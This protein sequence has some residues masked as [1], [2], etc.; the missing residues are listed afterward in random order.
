MNWNEV[1]V[2]CSSLYCLFTPPKSKEDKLAGNLSETAKT[3]L[4]K[5]YVEYMWGKRRQV[6]T[7][8]MEKG[9]ICEPEGIAMI[10]ALDGIAYVKNEERKSDEYITG[11]ADVV[12][13]KEVQDVKSCWDAESFIP[14]LVDGI[15]SADFYQMQGYMRL[16]NKPQARVPS[17]CDF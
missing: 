5:L 9:T 10:S 13:E 1:L 2:R 12:V 14:N 7:K 17:L 8:Q 15:S 16:W 4:N 3:H 6:T 11:E